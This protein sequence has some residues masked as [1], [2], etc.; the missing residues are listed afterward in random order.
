LLIT[1]IAAVI[2]LA[3]EVA[4]NVVLVG[5]FR[6]SLL[7]G[8]L[9]FGG[10]KVFQAGPEFGSCGKGQFGSELRCLSLFV[11]FKTVYCPEL[12]EK[13]FLMALC[14]VPPPADKV[15]GDDVL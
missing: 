6:D 11:C 10:G 1:A 8:A 4:E 5:F 15:H 2:E 9:D 13:L 14:A 7:D 12:D 3:A